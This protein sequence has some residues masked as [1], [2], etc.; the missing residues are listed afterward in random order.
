MSDLFGAG[1]QKLLAGARLAPESRARVDSLPRLIEAFD[2]EIEL[3]ASS[4][5]GGYAP[6]PGTGPSR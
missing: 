4:S 6:T 2:F 5:P 3:F 1:G